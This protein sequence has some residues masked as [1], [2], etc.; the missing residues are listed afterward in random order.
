MV[1]GGGSEEIVYSC[2]HV[3]PEPIR[4]VIKWLSVKKNFDTLELAKAFNVHRTSITRCL[5]GETSFV[6]RGRVALDMAVWKERQAK[7]QEVL[8][9]RNAAGKRQHP[10]SRAVAAVLKVENPEDSWSKAMVLRVIKNTGGKFYRMPRVPWLTDEQRQERLNF[11][12]KF[13]D[14]TDPKIHVDE[15]YVSVN[16]P[17]C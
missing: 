11:A 7:V 2:R 15:A 1:K 3:I 13:K 4:A 5:T 8:E 9:R 16:S 6:R 12:K 17:L 14:N 10:S